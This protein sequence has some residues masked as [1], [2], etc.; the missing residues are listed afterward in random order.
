MGGGY[1]AF[2]DD[3]LSVWSNPAGIATQPGGLSVGYQTFPLYEKNASANPPRRPDARIGLGEPGGVP[4]HIGA[5]YPIGTEE[6][7]QALGLTFVTP[8]FLSLAFDA[9]DFDVGGPLYSPNLWSTEQAFF[10]V[11]L[12]YARDFRF[13]A[14]GEEGWLPHLAIGLGADVGMTTFDMTDLYRGSSSSTGRT[15]YGGGFGLLLGLFDNTRDLKVNL[16]VAYQSS[17]V[18]DIEHLETQDPRPAPTF[19]WPD[20]FQVGV[21]VFLLDGLPLKITSEVQFVGWN[22]ASRKSEIPGL[23]DFRRTTTL[24]VGA[25]VRLPVDG[26]TTFFPRL[27]LRLSEAPWDSGQ[28]VRLPA[29]GEWQL[30]VSTRDSRFLVFSFGFGVSF[31]G[32]GGG[33]TSLDA[34]FD[35]G[36]DA[37][38]A[39]LGIGVGF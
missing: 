11:R 29:T 22:G 38:G 37:P 17:I 20:Q 28:E 32:A 33:V 5:V 18:F 23:G 6:R 31:A 10:R 2:E 39:T 8:M 1:S 19:N 35:I 30:S 3:P 15:N 4:A 26:T 21:L 25:E 12:A 14:V 9:P 24:S 34:S 16:G 27:G 7:P 13:K 36:G